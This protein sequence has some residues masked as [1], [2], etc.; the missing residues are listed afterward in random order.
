MPARAKLHQRR[1]AL[2]AG[3]FTLVEM[4]VVI[5]IIGIL[6]ALLL[7]AVQA[8]REAA[9][10]TQC[11]NHLKQIGLAVLNYESAHRVFP[12]GSA[13]PMGQGAAW[14]VYILPHL[15]QQAVY[16][17]YDFDSSP[18]A[19]ENLEATACVIP[20]YLCPSTARRMSDRMHE[21]SW[22]RN[23]NGQHDPGDFMG[24]IDYGG[25]HGFA[26]MDEPTSEPNGVLPWGNPPG[27]PLC[28]TAASIR[29][30]AS[31]TMMVGESTGRGFAKGTWARGTNVFDVTVSVNYRQGDELFSDHPGGV[32]AVFADGSVHF[33]PNGMD[34]NVLEAIC[35]RAA[36]DI[37]PGDALR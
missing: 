34:L 17:V 2:R 35:T 16:D 11:K 32:N 23:K 30:G 9:R 28:V 31:N 14:S 6:I 18:I 7:P 13:K 5:T 1:D 26:R 21:T 12:P 4:L 24:C 20:T 29:D 37:V 15:E 27:E 3:G 10:N 22:D 36:R 25:I 8:A 33:L 19:A